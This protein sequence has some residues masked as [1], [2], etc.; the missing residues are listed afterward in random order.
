MRLK[1]SFSYSPAPFTNSRSHFIFLVASFQVLSFQIFINFSFHRCNKS[2]FLHPP[3]HNRNWIGR[4]NSNHMPHATN[5]IE[6]QTKERSEAIIVAATV[7]RSFVVIA[8]IGSQICC[9]LRRSWV[10]NFTT[11]ATF[12]CCSPIREEKMKI[13]FSSSF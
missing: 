13:F 6:R 5:F 7:P 8:I 4:C 9:F 1:Y 11:S 10:T 2:H 12:Y 3:L